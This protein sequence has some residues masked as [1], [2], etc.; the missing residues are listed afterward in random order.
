MTTI[1]YGDV[2][3]ISHREKIFCILVALFSSV[4]FCYYLKVIGII[5]D[6]LAEKDENFR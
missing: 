4:F 1:G 3:P 5:I 2:V 6:L